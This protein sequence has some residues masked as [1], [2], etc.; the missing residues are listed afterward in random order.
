[1]A[2]GT[3]L[4]GRVAVV[5]GAGRGI[6]R[7]TAL[8]LAELGAGVVVNDTGVEL[9]GSG[10]DHS[11]AD[12]VVTEI[13]QAERLAVASYETVADFEAAGRIIQTALDAFGRID[14]LVNNAGIL[15]SAPI[16]ELDPELFARVV[17]VHLFGTFNC[18]RHASP[19]MKQ[20]NS[21]RIVNIVSRGGLVG[22]PNSAGYGAGKGGIFGLTNVVARD[23]APFG[24]NVNAVNPAATAT[25][26]VA[27]S[28]GAMAVAQ[29]P[30][31]VAVLIAYLCTDATTVTGQTFLAQ[32]GA[33]G[34]FPTFATT[35]TL[36]KE[37]R[38]TVDEL[39]AGV[40]RLDISPLAVL[41]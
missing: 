39:A 23:L 12:G 9:D 15:A 20:Q 16:Y 31:D 27:G 34:L 22:G 32:H 4:D 25:R 41:Y 5:T 10:H 1:M 19:H 33:V 24:I 28:P 29:E 11:V 13:T 8:M 35:K 7:A 37:G 2:E 18:I 40:P 17:G 3:R 38:W 30:E 6:G 36:V 21:G 26:M 14:I